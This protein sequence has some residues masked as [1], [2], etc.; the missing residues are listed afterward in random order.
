MG[1][2][3]SRVL[4]IGVV[5]RG[6]VVAERVLDRRTDVTV[7]SRP[8]CTVCVSAE[9][10]KEFPASVPLAIVHQGAYYV[11]VPADGSDAVK[12]RGGAGEGRDLKNLIVNLKGQKCIPVEG[13]TGGSVQLDQAILM[14]QFV[15]GDSV[16]TVTHEETVLRIGLV[17]DDR[18]L[19]DQTFHVGRRPITIG[20][21]KKC[22]IA[23]PDNEYKNATASFGHKQDSTFRVRLPKT[24]DFVL[25]FDGNPL[26]KIEALQKK[27]AVDS[28]DFVEFDLPLKARGRATLGPYKVL[29]Q[30]VKQSVTV[31]AVPRKSLLA[32]LA[33]PFVNDTTWTLSF[34]I[35]LLLIGS[36]IGQAMLFERTT[37][38]FLAQKLEEEQIRELIEVDIP[39]KEEEKKEEKPDIVPPD[40]KEIA[41]KEDEKKPDKKAEPK[42]EA[43]GKQA[44][45][46]D[47]IKHDRDVVL[48]KTVAGAFVNTKLFADDGG[49]DGSVQANRQAFGGAEAADGA[50]PGG[51]LK[52]EGAGGGGGSVEK[53]G[54][55]GG[56]GFGERKSDIAKVDAPVKREAVAQIKLGGLDG[57]DAGGSKGDI[58]KAIS[59]KAGVVKQ[60]YEAALR[61]NPE[62]GGKVV[63]GFTVGTAGTVTAVNISGAEGGFS[64]CIR[65]KFMNIRGL[66]ILAAPQNFSQAYVFSK[67]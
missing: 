35:A 36:I 63:V 6:Q 61:D 59:R 8:E 39:E 20:S 22:D 65:A 46:N 33:T 18:L 66:P 56:K 42:I 62:I 1:L 5:W 19:S 25:A 34:I 13:Y 4:R 31:P 15:R 47:K 32:Q 53:V 45:P 57:D 60:C 7:G 51:A 41:K 27:V 3:T 28:G 38:R 9:E 10:Y 58:G 40:V 37:G 23:L 11:V 50:G 67:G 43:P 17:H 52:L 55:G 14:F 21:D 44:D 29:F 2:D 49:D 54:A 30:V 48:N 24:S 16:P 12:L 26:T 64:D